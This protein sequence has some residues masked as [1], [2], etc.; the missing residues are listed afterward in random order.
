[1]SRN[2]RSGRSADKGVAPSPVALPVPAAPA[3]PADA[4]SFP[5]PGQGGRRLA[6]D[7][8]RVEAFLVALAKY[9]VAEAHRRARTMVT[10]AV[11]DASSGHP[12]VTRDDRPGKGGG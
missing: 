2:R 6:L 7:P 3:P 12:A 9:S 4:L 5:T 10:V 1:M 8:V 11:S